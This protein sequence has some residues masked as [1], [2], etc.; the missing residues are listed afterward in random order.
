MRT[1]HLAT[2]WSPV[3]GTSVSVGLVLG[4]VVLVAAAILGGRLGLA[5][6]ALAVTLPGLLLQDGWRFA[7]F[8]CGRGAQAFLT[9]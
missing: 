6:V 8:S 9:T 2:R 4:A 3:T 7:F 1:G 5:F